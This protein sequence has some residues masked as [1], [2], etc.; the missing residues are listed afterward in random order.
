MNTLTRGAVVLLDPA[1][2]DTVLSRVASAA[3]A[4]Y[5]GKDVEEVGYTVDEDVDWAIAPARGLDPLVRAEWRRR[6]AE[7]ISDPNADRRAF[8]ADLKSLASPR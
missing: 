8:I 7:V 1:V 5:P 6:I 3:F 2:V 4:Y